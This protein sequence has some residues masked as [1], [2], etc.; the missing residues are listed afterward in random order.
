[1]KGGSTR[2]T[3]VTSESDSDIYVYVWEPMLQREEKQM[4]R[5]KA[6]VLRKM[7]ILLLVCM[8]VTAVAV[9]VAVGPSYASQRNTNAGPSLKG[10]TFA[11]VTY[12]LDSYGTALSGWIK[13]DVQALGGKLI[14]DNGKADAT[15]QLAELDDLITEKVNGILW[16]P[17]AANSAGPEIKKVQAAG[18][19]LVLYG[20]YADPKVTH[21]PVPQVDI[22]D[23]NATFKAGQD[24]ARFVTKRW[25]GQP[26]KVIA[27]NYH[28]EPIAVRRTEGFIAGLKSVRKDTKIVFDQDVLTDSTSARTKMQNIITSTPDFNVVEP[29][30]G[31]TWVGVMSALSSAGRGKA[32]NKVPTSEWILGIDGT[33][34]EL[35]A[36]FDKTNATMGVIM[37]APFETAQHQLNTLFSVMSGK[38]KPTANYLIN[39]AGT[40]LP[41]N[42]PLAAKIYNHEYRYVRAFKPL[43]C[44]KYK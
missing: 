16:Q 27:F 43:N 22:D 15:A 26:P 2:A 7:S 25:P 14:V 41:A 13:Q 19:P 37:L 34:A 35:N 17:V 4:M 42:C 20:S 33:P 11:I 36:L 12:W 39:S 28:T 5:K 18:I 10:K 9:G 8:V 38:L 44:A 32:V 24:A 6:F 1:M 21:A 40:L 23:Y 31:D 3:E 29:Y 30:A